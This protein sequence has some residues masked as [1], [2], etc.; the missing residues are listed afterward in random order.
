M[1]L[2]IQGIH[3]PLIKAEGLS[4][5]ELLQACQDFEAMFLQQMLKE[6]RKTVPKDGIIPQSHEQDIFTAMFD[7][8]VAKKMSNQGGVGLAEMLFEQLRD[9]SQDKKSDSDG[10]VINGTKYHTING[11]R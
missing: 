2:R 10:V 4:N 7:E 9:K 8:E 3:T 11:S 6:M 1:K 5:K